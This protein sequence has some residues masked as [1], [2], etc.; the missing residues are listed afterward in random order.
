[1][2]YGHARNA[3]SHQGILQ[4]FKTG[5]LTD[6][7]HL[8]KLGAGALVKGRHLLHGNGLR[9]GHLTADHHRRVLGGGIRHHGEAGVSREQAVLG[10]IQTGD[11]LL[12]RNP[13]A[14]GLFDEDEH[15]RNDDRHI[16][17]DAD[18]AQALDT[19]EMEAAAVEQTLLG[20]NAGGEQ[21][22]QNG[23]QGA[24]DTVDGN[25]AHRIINLHNLVEELHG[26][27]HHDAEHR[28]HNGGAK[29]GDRVA[30]GGDAHQSGQRGVVGHGHI[31]LAVTNPGEDQRHAAG[32]GRGQIGVEEDQTRA[33]DCLV[34][35][36]GHGGSAVE[37]EPAE[38]E[39]EHAQRREGQ[40]VTQNGLGLAI[41]VILA[42]P[43]A[44][45]GRADQGAHAADH[46][47]R[48][49]AGEIMEAKLAQPAAAP[50]PVAG[51]GVDKQGDTG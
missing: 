19:Q 8:G 39:D 38:P 51:D 10:D 23:A 4:G 9:H 41:G 47:N 27:H 26:Q 33:G 43:G 28:A 11:L 30:S 45:H 7:F 15:H 29:R 22:G 31:G 44:Q 20:G 48:R 50:D 36:H 12:R 3:N 1:M 46:V 6:D 32:H 14:D 49:G 2:G 42:D 35:I 25:R 13:Q 34:G 17:D 37:A 5:F 40:V 24:A 21:A 16:G 18:H